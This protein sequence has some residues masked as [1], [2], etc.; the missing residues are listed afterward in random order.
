MCSIKSEGLKVRNPQP[1]GRG[2]LSSV[3]ERSDQAFTSSA[4]NAGVCGEFSEK[5]W[6]YGNTGYAVVK[7]WLYQR[8][9]SR[10]GSS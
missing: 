9:C 3:M 2:A 4:S 7:L 5:C 10:L 8:P 6:N 1:M